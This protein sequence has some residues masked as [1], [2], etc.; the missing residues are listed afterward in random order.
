MAAVLIVFSF[1]FRDA[2]PGDAIDA[3]DAARGI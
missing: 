2:R 1:L 3:E